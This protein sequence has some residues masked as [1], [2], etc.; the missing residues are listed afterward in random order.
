MAELNLDRILAEATLKQLE[1]FKEQV[2]K[3]QEAAW[4]EGYIAADNGKDEKTNP[5]LKEH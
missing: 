4:N 1:M 2:R 3:L 5:Y